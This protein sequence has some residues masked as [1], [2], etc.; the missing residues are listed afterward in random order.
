MI[1]VSENKAIGIWVK[2]TGKKHLSRFAN[3]SMIFIQDILLFGYRGCNRAIQL[4]NQILHI[5]WFGMLLCVCGGVCV[6]VWGGGGGG[7]GL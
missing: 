2:I 1:T 3:T 4:F 5:V 7:G 6:C